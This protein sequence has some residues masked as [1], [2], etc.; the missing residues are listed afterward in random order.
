[1][2]AQFERFTI[3]MTATQAKSAY[4]SGQCWHD[5]IELLKDKKIIR[6]LKEIS[7]VDLAEELSEYGAWSDNELQSRRDNEERIVWI[8]AGNICDD[9]ACRGL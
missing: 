7:C 8:A 9:L 6:Q 1:M 5:I 3:E 4:H 2:I